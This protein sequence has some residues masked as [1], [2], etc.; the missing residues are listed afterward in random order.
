VLK[1]VGDEPGELALL[2][3]ALWRTWSEAKGHSPDLVRAY[4]TIGRVEGALA[5]AAE[6]VFQRLSDDERQRAET[7]FV[8]L[9]RP[10]EAGGATRRVAMLS[11][12][13]E[14]TRTLAEKLSR[15][16]QWRLLSFGEGTVEI[17]HEQ[18]ATQWLR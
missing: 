8:R 9:V 10:G 12:F 7:I 6:G 18:L 16:E 11:E 14:P 1:D 4:G 5:Q 2:Q 17:A 15:E 3:M 13:D